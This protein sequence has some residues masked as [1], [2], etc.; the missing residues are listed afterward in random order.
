MRAF[1]VTCASD[2][3]SLS[4]QVVRVP[5]V[6]RKSIR[7]VSKLHITQ[8]YL[9][10]TF[11]KK[12]VLHKCNLLIVLSWVLASF[13]V[14]HITQTVPRK[15]HYPFSFINSGMKTYF[16]NSSIRISIWYFTSANE[17]CKPLI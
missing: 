9:F 7:A 3:T 17:C 6:P 2:M 8:N 12:L 1:V 14:T 13:K 10:S 4:P 11:L 15:K 16:S 5:R